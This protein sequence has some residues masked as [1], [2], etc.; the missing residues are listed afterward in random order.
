MFFA[1][2]SHSPSDRA[3]KAERAVWPLPAGGGKD[4]VKDSIG[5]KLSSSG[6][7]MKSLVSAV[8]TVITVEPNG[9]AKLRLPTMLVIGHPG[10]KGQKSR[11][12]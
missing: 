12:R 6:S 1:D 8:V 3:A 9:Q 7:R 2:L 4:A 11:S 5:I 10:G